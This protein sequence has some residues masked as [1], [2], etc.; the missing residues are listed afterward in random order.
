VDHEDD[1][2]DEI[3]AI[4]TPTVELTPDA[5][6]RIPEKAKLRVQLYPAK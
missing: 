3:R 6:K 2:Y 5:W 1:R 4:G